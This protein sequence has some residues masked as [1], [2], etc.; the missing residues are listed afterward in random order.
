[1]QFPK[2][3]PLQT[4]FV[5][6]FIASAILVIIYLSLTSPHFAYAVDLDS[7]IPPDHN[8]PIILDDGFIF[9]GFEEELEYGDVEQESSDMLSAR[10]VSAV[11]PQALVNNYAS[12]SNIA[13]GVTQIWMFPKESIFNST[14]IPGLVLP[15]DINVEDKQSLVRDEL[16][17]RQQSKKQVYITLNTC[18]QP[19]A[20]GSSGNEIPPQLQLYVSRSSSDTSPGPSDS[21]SQKY[22]VSGGY[23]IA[24]I[25]VDDDVYVAVSAPNATSFSG[26]YNYAIAASV[27]KPYHGMDDSTPNLLFV[28]GDNHAALLITN[29][30]TE[31]NS[32]S[33]IFQEWMTMR[34]PWGV[35]AQNTNND[36]SI[37]GVQNSYC[38]LSHYAQI[39]ANL[40]D[41]DPANIAGMTS[42]GLGGKPKEQFYIQGLNA[43]STYWGFLAIASNSTPGVIG[44][45][46]KI[47]AAMNFSTKSGKQADF[48]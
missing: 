33:Q 32:S 43:T 7:R 20:N 26:E 16:R 25:E 22:T 41:A 17:R 3:T 46:G 44:G 45:G 42:R 1:M 11:V 35:F 30:T 31:A 13:L 39:A 9:E 8:H 28:D 6:S 29:D 47:W 4:R 10:D 18:L 21:G 48:R 5:A 23:G 36:S 37:L 34:P 2:L 15:G 12:L 38:G 40:P 14:G 24:T 27:D 19:F